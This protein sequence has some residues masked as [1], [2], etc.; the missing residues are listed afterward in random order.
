MLPRSGRRTKYQI[1]TYR[2]LKNWSSTLERRWCPSGALLGFWR[3]LRSVIPGRWASITNRAFDRGERL[4]VGQLNHVV[5]VPHLEWYA[6]LTEKLADPLP[7]QAESDS[8]LACCDVVCPILFHAE[9]IRP[10][11]GVQFPFV[12]G[13]QPMYLLTTNNPSPTAASTIAATQNPAVE[14]ADAAKAR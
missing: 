2:P 12:S 4:Q 8:S 3:W 10:M 5:A 14:G 1:P 6:A 7:T 9:N 11:R 13:N